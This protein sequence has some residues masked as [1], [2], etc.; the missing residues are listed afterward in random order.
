LYVRR[1]DDIIQNRYRR[2]GLIRLVSLL[3]TILT[4][5]LLKMSPPRGERVLVTGGGGL[6]GSRLV[7]RLIPYN[8]VK[9]LD[10]F[11]T[12]DSEQL[13]NDVEI[14]CSDINNQTAL[15]SGLRDA[16]VVFHQAGVSGT[17]A[18]K[19]NLL[20]SHE[21]NTTGTLRLLKECTNR[22]LRVIIASS[23]SVYGSQPSG[24]IPETADT[25]PTT[26]YQYLTKHPRLAVSAA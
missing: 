6:I 14:I 16:T 9:A 19:A 23:A 2:H 25:R 22:D 10:H 24:P 5:T 26:N 20:R 21:V 13:P 8:E 17:T 4:K 12:T 1:S 18:C 7:K 3:Q 11:Q 15:Q